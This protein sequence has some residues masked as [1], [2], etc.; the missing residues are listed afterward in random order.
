M[1]RA[2]LKIGG[3]ILRSRE[4]LETI[5]KILKMNSGRE[6]IL[7]VSALSGVTDTL[8]GAYAHSKDV[9]AELRR[10]HQ[11]Y[12]DVQNEA[13]DAKFKELSK[14]LSEKKKSVERKERVSAF[15]ERL[16]AIAVAEYLNAHGIPA[17]AMDAEE[18]GI[19]ADGRFEKANC[20]L[21]KTK[22]NFKTR[23][24]PKIAGKTLVIT[25]YYG[26]DGNGNVN[27]FGRG[28][29]DYSAAVVAV[30]SSAQVLEIWKDVEGFMS[31][32]PRVVK[33]ARKLDEIS[34]DEAK[35][36]GY[37]GAK[38]LHPRTMDALRGSKVFAQIKSVLA[39]EMPGTRIVEERTRKTGKIITSIAAKKGTC[40]VNIRGAE[41]VDVPGVAA[42]IFTAIAKKGVS[43]DTIATSQV[44][45]TFT[46]DENDA[47]TAE[48]A[49]RAMPHL[50]GDFEMSRGLAVVGVV[51][52]EMNV[53]NTAARIFAAVGRRRINI[54]MIS[55]A[56]LGIN[57]TLIVKRE[58]ADECIRAIHEEFVLGE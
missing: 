37:L 22:E 5:V 56:A 29:S 35:E 8:L 55:Q 6:N 27:T 44:N 41:M 4:D 11:A 9:S 48:K 18:C 47:E 3:G 20:V 51:G 17:L 10:K 24:I 26:I 53:P 33:D 25:G 54:S 39:P 42:Q 52:D 1:T 30:A 31:A 15:G 23:V 58:D 16:S 38:I 45:I 13:L 50:V 43:I 49:L 12:F 21:E 14:L 57:V 34:F 19:A 46:I 36:L 7:V 28:G 40:V 32:D 2:V